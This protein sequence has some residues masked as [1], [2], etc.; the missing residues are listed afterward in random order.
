MEI[1][2]EMARMRLFGILAGALALGLLALTAAAAGA[3]STKRVELKM[4]G[5]PLT[6]GA[7]VLLVA[8]YSLGDC[9]WEEQELKV[10]VN[11]ASVDKLSR[12]AEAGQL[13]GCG[14]G[15]KAVEITNAHKMIVRL[16]PL[17]IH[18]GGPCVYEFKAISAAYTEEEWGPEIYGSASGTLN[19]AESSR[20]AGCTKT[21]AT[22]FDMALS[23]VEARL[24]S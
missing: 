6:R 15:V 7:E 12:G 2:V 17:R 23:G 19:K 3:A 16:A 22:A 11:R 1:R 9:Y 10:T 8:G 20:T 18:V 21:R 4:E 5:K 24:T 13:E 14:G